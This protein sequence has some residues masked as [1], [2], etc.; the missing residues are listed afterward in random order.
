M[1]NLLEIIVNNQHSI[2]PTII[3]VISII[4]IIAISI[5]FIKRLHQ[6]SKTA[7][8]DLE[9]I[10]NKAKQQIQEEKDKK[11]SH[12]CKYCGGNIPAGQHKCPNCG[13]TH[14]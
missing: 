9:D 5:T 8:K 13:A 12:E 14:K 10:S 3:I 1:T 6:Y 2:L 11:S 7:N 4:I